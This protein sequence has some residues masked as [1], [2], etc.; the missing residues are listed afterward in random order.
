MAQD[1]QAKQPI[2]LTREQFREL[3]HEL[4]D[5][6]AEFF[7][8]LPRRPLTRG[9]TPTQVRAL[10]GSGSLPE[11]GED[12]RVFLGKSAEIL[13]ENSLFNA[14]PLFLGYITSPAA[15]LG[16]LGDFLASALNPN[17]G[18][19]V[20]APVA[21]EIER[22]SIRWMAELIGYETECGGI[23]V[24]GGNMANFVGFL[25]GRSAKAPWAA[26]AGLRSGKVLRAYVAKT[27]HTWVHKAADMYGHGSDSVRWIDIDAQSRIDVRA[28]RRQIEADRAAGDQPFLVVGSAGTVAIGAVD[29]LPELAALCREFGLWF[30]VDGAYGA[31]AAAARTGAPPELRQGLSLA[32]SIAMDPHKWLYAP[33]EAGCTLVRD[34]ELMRRA[35]S[36]HPDYYKFDEIGGEFPLSYVDYGPQNSRGFRALKVWLALKQVGR[37]GYEQMIER[38]MQLARRLY[39]LVEAHPEFEARTQHLSIATFRYVPKGFD[40][41]RADAQATLNRLNET[42]LTQVQ[43]GGEAFLSNAVVDGDYLLR[44]CIVNFRTTEADIDRLPEILARAGCEVAAQLR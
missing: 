5:R 39:E 27:A 11:H 16:V 3:G 25:V 30:H 1:P 23:L 10:I 28:L 18:A 33:L 13:V 8:A 12:P 2:D 14:H 43:R 35:F 6:I 4:V 17:C 29:P 15:P 34:P 20:L 31:F 42:L 22:Q 40:L 21:T 9:L 24:S 7:E 26:K 38:D 19:W 41:K 37:V 32:D 36:Y 44:A